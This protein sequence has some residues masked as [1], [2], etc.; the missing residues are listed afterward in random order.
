MDLLVMLYT[1]AHPEHVARIVQLDPVPIRYD[2]KYP[3]GLSEN[4]ATSLDP[5]AAK[6]LDDLQQ[7][8]FDRSHPKEYCDRLGV[9]RF[10]LVGDPTHVDRLGVPK[11]G[12]CDFEN[13]W[14]VNLNPHFEA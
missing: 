5:A 6:K 1:V 10:A 2:T 4:Y 8:G 11:T 12:L 14:P 3:A 9:Q 7:Q 13:E